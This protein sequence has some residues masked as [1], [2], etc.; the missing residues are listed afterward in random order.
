MRLISVMLA[1]LLLFGCSSWQQNAVPMHQNPDYYPYLQPSFDEYLLETKAWLANNRTFISD[2]KDKELAMNMPFV[3]RTK[4]PLKG[5]VMLVHGLGD[6][7]YSFSD[8]GPTLADKGLDVYVLLLPGHGSDPSHMMMPSY[9]DWQTLVDHYALQL[10]GQY[11]SLWLG[12]FSTGAN[13]VT[14]YAARNPQI[15]GLFLFSPAYR[16]HS[17]VLEALAPV[18]AGLF[19]WGWQ[20]EEDNLARYTSSTFNAAAAYAKSASAV[21]EILEHQRIEIPT[22]ILISETDSVVDS[23]FIR[24][25]FTS[26]FSHADSRLLWHGNL[27]EPAARVKVLN[28]SLPHF[29]IINGSHMSVLFRACNPYYGIRAEKRLCHNSMDNDQLLHC[30]QAD[31]VWKGAWGTDAGDK[32]FARLTWNPYY[33][34]FDREAARLLSAQ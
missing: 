4:Q 19:D 17:P 31:S 22:L 34:E 3:I 11:D 24:E 14:H 8:I 9:Q 18:A 21:R 15:A 1:V 16:T 12:G 27:S 6:S 20:V 25:H 26:H 29:K 33:F 10:E 5:A 7:P 28:M 30:Q 32:P 13:L 23:T 2:D